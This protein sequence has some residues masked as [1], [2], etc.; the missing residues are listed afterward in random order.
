MTDPLL[1]LGVQRALQEGLPI[2]QRPYLALA[3]QLGA[4]EQQVIDAIA[5][6]QDSGN[7]K[8]FGMVLKHRELGY[9]ANAMV[10]WDVPNDRVDRVGNE[11]GEEPCVTLSYRRPRRPPYWNYNLF[12]M[13]HGTSREEVTA[14]LEDIVSRRGLD[15]P[16]QVL[17][18]SKCFKQ[19]GAVYV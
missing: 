13:I 1:L 18:S 16:H 19:R 3:D 10:V 9:R 15:Y 6:L 17:F 4:S 12:C 11:L 8:R 14:Q 7:I 2:V 5:R